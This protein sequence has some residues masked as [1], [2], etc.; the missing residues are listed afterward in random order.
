[1]E[2]VGLIEKMDDGHKWKYYELTK[3]GSEIIGPKELRVWILLSL[4][5]VALVLSVFSMLPTQMAGEQTADFAMENAPEA[6]A[7]GDSAGAAEPMLMTATQEAA[8]AKAITTMPEEA[9]EDMVPPA[10]AGISAL[11]M[12]ACVAMLVR[13][14]MKAST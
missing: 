5:S 4:A 13:N 6:Y 1:L 8:D 14:R 10:V 3:K 9:W 7:S 11:T 2:K 12:A